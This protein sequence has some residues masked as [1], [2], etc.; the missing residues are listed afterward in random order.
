MSL[1]FLIDKDLAGIIFSVETYWQNVFALVTSTL[2]VYVCILKLKI[3]NLCD[4]Y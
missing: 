4:G 2:C 1:T 3:H